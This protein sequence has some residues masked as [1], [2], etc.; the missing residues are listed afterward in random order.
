MKLNLETIARPSEWPAGYELPQF[1]VAKMTAA[2]REN[3]TWLHVGAGNIFRI[4]VAAAQQDLLEAGLADT[5]I[6]V[7]E[8]YDERIV[9]QSFE[10]FD[11][12]SLA[13]T[14]NA[15]G[16]ADKRVIA[17]VAQAFTQ[18]LPRLSTTMSKPSLQMISFTITEKGYAVDPSAVSK[19]RFMATTA[20]EQVTAGLYSRFESGAPPLALVAM[21][22]FSENGTKLEAAITA[23]AKA[24]HASPAFMEY[25]KT[26]SF[27]WTMIDKITPRPSEKVAEL[28]EADGYEDVQ[29]HETPK[30]TFVASFVNAEA[31]GYL[32]IE[33][34]F[35]N[36]RPPLEKAGVYVTDKETVLKM[37]LMKVCACLNPLHTILAVSGMLLN[38]ETISDCMKDD[39]LVKLIRKSADE[40]LPTIDHP[41]IIDPKDFLEEVLTQRF[42]NPFIPDAPARI[43]SDTSQKIPV[44][45]GVALAKRAELGLPN[46]KLEVIPLF[47]ALWLRYRMGLDDQGAEL[48]LSP[49]P[50]LPEH[51]K[52]LLGQSFGA[53]IDLKPLLR[54]S[55]TFGVDLYK[56]GLGDKIEKTFALLSEGIGAVSKNL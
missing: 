42:P 31:P 27:P 37:D 36:G 28:L 2:T 50:N 56:A 14:L 51:F 41:G 10:P 45:F 30:H 26:L 33:D 39:R 8:A 11:N 1:D 25:L 23:I 49:D 44:R 40:A 4:F 24:W 5:G 16:S 13:V 29:I 22:N 34:C 21:D 35:P 54:D 15:D 3:P 19:S 6:I 12:L 32:L 20:L 48:N 43:A 7:Y 17:S 53:K 46:T 9:P 47:I 38:Y 52:I 55:K 18:D